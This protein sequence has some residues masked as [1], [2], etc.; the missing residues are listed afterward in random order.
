[1]TSPAPPDPER[2]RLG[3]AFASF[4]TDAIDLVST[5]LAGATHLVS[6]RKGVYAVN[7]QQ[8]TH[9]LSGFC[10]GLTLRGNEIF[11]FEACDQP[12]SPLRR[13]RI[14]RLFREGDRIV[15]AEVIARGLDNGCHQVDFLRNRLHVVDTYN[16]RLIRFSSGMTASEELL[17]LPIPPEGRWSNTDPRYVHA[18]SLLAVGNTNLLLLHNTSEHTGRLSEVA[19]YDEAWN[20][21][22]RWSLEGKSCHGLALL[23]DGTLLTCDSIAGDL[24][25]AQGLRVHISPHFTRGLSIGNDQIVVGTSPRATR[26]QRLAS[27]GTVTFLDRDFRQQAVLSLPGAPTEIRRLDGKDAGSSSYLEQMPWGNTLKA[28]T[29]VA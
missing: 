6:S 10:F 27:E 20:P 11:V 15:S 14:V 22:G 29:S 9:I 7:E 13:G 24:I 19:L 26:E 28:G 21:A 5:S 8:W 18:N 17:P 2:A 4:D 25:S 16:Q 1:M 3:K 23:E 12:R